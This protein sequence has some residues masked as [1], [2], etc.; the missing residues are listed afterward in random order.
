MD[1]G[2]R[3][4]IALNPQIEIDG[5]LV[6]LALDLEVA[7]FRRLMEQGR[8][9]TL[10]ERGVGEDAGLYRASFYYG[11]RRARLVVDASGTP[12]TDR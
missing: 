6:A 2:R 8:I 7:E 11:D 10:C 12:V 5:A 9:S 1:T 4:G 3:I